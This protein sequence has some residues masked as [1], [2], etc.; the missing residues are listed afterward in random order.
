[1]LVIL[2][3]CYLVYSNSFYMTP[4]KVTTKTFNNENIKVYEPLNTEKNNIL[5]F[6]GANSF[7]PGEVYSSFLSNVAQ[8]NITTHVCSNNLLTNNKIYSNIES[9]GETIVVGHSTGCINAIEFCNNNPDVKK[10]VLMDAVDNSYLYNKKYN[11]IPNKI[12]DN[13]V[14]KIVDSVKVLPF[15]DKVRYDD[16][17]IDEEE[18]ALNYVNEVLFLNARKSYTWDLLDKKFPFIPA[19]G[20]HRDTIKYKN[21]NVNEITIYAEDF[22]HTDILDEIWANN[23]HNTISRGTEDRSSENLN[24]YHKWLAT[25]IYIFINKENVL[26][27]I[28]TNDIVKQIK[29]TCE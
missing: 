5:F 10:I 28:T 12:T 18:I 4:F 13:I 27:V 9:N 3:I 2:L 26:E 17:E 23:M 21:D 25:I 19:F 8:Y 29:S 6:T 20:I 15:F 16:V 22:G 7:I 1:M 11:N 14:K 24:L